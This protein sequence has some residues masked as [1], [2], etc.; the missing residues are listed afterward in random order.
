MSKLQCE[1]NKFSA[2]DTRDNVMS[3]WFKP[4]QLLQTVQ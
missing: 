4:R 3:R 1:K 2:M